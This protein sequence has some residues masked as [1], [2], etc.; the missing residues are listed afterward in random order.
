MSAA[1]NINNHV[2]VALL[3][4]VPGPLEVHEA[5]KA[6]DDEHGRLVVAVVGGEVFGVRHAWERDRGEE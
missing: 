5:L 3:S 1:I 2:T 6:A 4:L